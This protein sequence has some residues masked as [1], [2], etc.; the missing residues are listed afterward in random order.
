MHGVV[1][2]VRNG[3]IAVSTLLIA[4]QHFASMIGT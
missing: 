1:I 2:V 3:L 4:I